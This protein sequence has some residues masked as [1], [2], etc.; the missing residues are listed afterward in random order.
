MLG[1]LQS[2]YEAFAYSAV[3]AIFLRSVNAETYYRFCRGEVTDLE[4]MDEIFNYPGIKS[5]K[6]T[7]DGCLL[8]AFIIEGAKEI[9]SKKENYPEEDIRSPLLTRYRDIVESGDSSLE[10]DQMHAKKIIE[11][12]ESF[13]KPF[14]RIG[15]LHSIHRIELLTPE[16]I[17]PN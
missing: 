14:N 1:S 11:L 10:K 13:N 4:V 12:I 3:V 5:L 9:L 6:G 15:F 8:E 2:N 16:L 17:E 7:H